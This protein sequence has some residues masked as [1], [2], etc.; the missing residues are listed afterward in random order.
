MIA[1]FSTD[2]RKAE[3]ST[4]QQAC[5]ESHSVISVSNSPVKQWLKNESW[6]TTRP[7]AWE[8]KSRLGTVHARLWIRL[9]SP[10]G[11]IL[12]VPQLVSGRGRGWRRTISGDY[13]PRAV[14]LLHVPVSWLWEAKGP[15]SHLIS[16]RGI[17]EQG[18]KSGSKQ[19]P[20]TWLCSSSSWAAAQGV[21]S[22]GISSGDLTKSAWKEKRGITE[23]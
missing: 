22:L 18:E 6:E 21:L 16:C 17:F 5:N 7:G 9:H 14:V 10:Q 11:H 1:N 8:K 19:Q 2:H 4:W 12:P 23:G 15:T 20:W 3:P 13:F